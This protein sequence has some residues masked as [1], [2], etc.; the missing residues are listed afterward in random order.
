MRFCASC[1][2]ELGVGRFCTN[3]G[4]PVDRSSERAPAPPD[5]T[6]PDP[7]VDSPAESALRRP[8]L[9]VQ[10]DELDQVPSVPDPAEP[11]LSEPEPASL[12]T[13]SPDPAATGLHAAPISEVVGPDT[14]E[15][16]A[17]RRD[18]AMG[19]PAPRTPPSADDMP[20][21]PRYP[22]F[23]D[24]LDATMTRTDLATVRSESDTGLLSRF[25]QHPE[26]TR[27]SARTADEALAA[28]H[29]AAESDGYVYAEPRRLPR[30][31]W[32]IAAAV[33]VILAIAAGVLWWL[34]GGADESA[35]DQASA[36]PA[37]PAAESLLIG[38]TAQVPGEA[39]PSREL[40]GSKVTYGAANLL[41]GDPATAWRVAGDAAGRKIMLTFAETVTIDEVGLVNGYA[42]QAA[43]AQGRR[44]DWYHGHR[45][46]SQVVWVFDD[47]TEVPQTLGRDREAQTIPIDGL[48]TRTLTLRLVD[49]SAPGTGRSSRNF[50]A[51][52][53]LVVTGTPAS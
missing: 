2:H 19:P 24:E 20:P 27:L 35:G 49:V 46:I 44:F 48:T 17:A 4:Q 51:I 34:F 43:D 52:S 53:D 7:I 22:L 42:K 31:L 6:I 3:C 1:G 14:E 30:L 12:E 50:T 37:T 38:A 26:T 25:D 33:V 18:A 10:P 39:A 21:P 16:R 45:T 9:G 15:R 28:L 11:E 8:R 13:A 47:G 29:L 36:E 41:D 5:P 40:T 23:A 32:L